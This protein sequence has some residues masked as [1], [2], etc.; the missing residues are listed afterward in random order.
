MWRLSGIERDVYLFAVPKVRISD[1]FVKAGL[2]AQYAKGVFNLDVK[3][4]NGGRKDIQGYNLDINLYDKSA[5]EKVYSE[6]KR[7]DI[8]PGMKSALNFNALI[9]TV[10]QW[11][12]ESPNLYKLTIQLFDKENNLLQATGCKTGFRTSEIKNGQLLVNG[13]AILIKGVNRHEHDPY[14]GHVITVESMKKD[15]EL[16]KKFNINAVRTSHYPNDPMWYKLCDE[17]GLYL[18]G[19]ANIESHGYGYDPDKTLGNNPDYMETHLYRTRNMVE[20]DK[21][22]P[23]VIVW[24]LG[25]EAGAGVN[26]LATYQWAKNRDKT[27]PVSYEIRELGNKLSDRHSD[28]KGDMY[29]SIKKAQNYLNTNPDRPFIWVEYSIIYGNSLGMFQDFWDLVESN[30]QH[31]GGFIWDWADKCLIKTNDKGKN[32][33]GFGGDFEPEGVHHDMDDGANGLVWPDR[34][35]KPGL[36][37]VKKVYQNIKIIPL[38]IDDYR[39]MIMNKFDFTSLENYKVK[40]ELQANGLTIQQGELPVMNILP[41]NSKVFRIDDIDLRPQPGVE[42]FINF[43]TVTMKA[44]E[45]VKAG[46]I[47]ASEQYKLPVSLMAEM[48][49]PDN[50]EEITVKTYPG[51]YL[52]SG[53]NF[54]ATFDR[55]TGNLA[56]YKFKG[57]EL[58]EDGLQINFWRA[59]TNVDYDNKMPVRCKVWRNAGKERVVISDSLVRVTE[60]EC[61]LVFNF[62]LPGTGSKYRSEYIVYGSGEVTV[63]NLFMKGDKDLPELPRFGMSITLPEGYENM[64]WF[65]RGPYENYPDRKTAFDVGLY[66]SSVIE[67]F[68]PYVRVQETGNKSDVRWVTFMDNR[69]KGIKFS[70]MPLLNVGALH[71]SIDD[72]DTGD[73]KRGVHPGDLE[74]RKQ[75]YVNLDLQQSGLGKN[76][77]WRIKINRYSM[78]AKD[79]SYRFTISPVE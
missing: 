56:G 1:F 18:Y 58:I 67:Q 53:S 2:D 79:Y 17:Y 6:R 59:P 61:R 69:G 54:T 39:F 37:E 50:Y 66:E 11:S 64:K 60:G 42:Y 13:K 12:A 19:E 20:R 4:E 21:N 29:L 47:V 70:G 3:L 9:D 33:W 48:P 28:I 14:T 63:N 8:R 31:Q 24:S 30:R 38:D 16:M 65:G 10:R 23:S 22:H 27:R 62:D 7:I 15:I 25:N 51:K 35:I 77:D 76:D 45:L 36:W 34:Q 40:W 41:G 46:H 71:Y 78:L 75:I 68:M 49:K 32:I 52:V 57:E 26:F 72:L 55:K 74:P 43:K 73:E 5:G 44:T